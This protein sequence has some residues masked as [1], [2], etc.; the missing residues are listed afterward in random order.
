[1]CLNTPLFGIFAVERTFVFANC[2]LKCIAKSVVEYHKTPRSYI[3]GAEQYPEGSSSVQAAASEGAREGGVLT[4]F[5][6]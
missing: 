3:E 5:I 2:P 1:M 6:P 4:L